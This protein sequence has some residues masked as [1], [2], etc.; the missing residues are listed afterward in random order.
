MAPLALAVIPAQLPPILP[1]I[2]P[3]VPDVSPVPSEVAPVLPPFMPVPPEFPGRSGPCLAGGL[4]RQGRH[5]PEEEDA[6][7][8][9][10][11]ITHLEFSR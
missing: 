4:G 1:E 5:G 10:V 7:Q 3:V 11:V 6:Q 9:H 8:C 2:P